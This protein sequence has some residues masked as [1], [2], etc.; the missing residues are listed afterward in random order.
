MNA[1]RGSA[2][3]KFLAQIKSALR[4]GGDIRWR[5]QSRIYLTLLKAEGL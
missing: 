5:D 4:R 1:N 2:A 3:K